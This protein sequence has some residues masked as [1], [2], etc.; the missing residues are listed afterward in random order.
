MA[1]YQ[2]RRLG[3]IDDIRCGARSLLASKTSKA[4]CVLFAFGTGGANGSSGLL[5]WSL[6]D[7]TNQLPNGLALLVATVALVR[8][9][10]LT[11]L[12][13]PLPLA[14]SGSRNR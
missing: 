2:P 5:N 12:P 4:Y 7:T 1:L 14:D 9:D 6:L 13:L 3:E 8:L 10:H 11:V